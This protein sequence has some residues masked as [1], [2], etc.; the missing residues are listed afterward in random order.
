[1]YKLSDEKRT[2]DNDNLVLLV[3]GN[4]WWTSFKDRIKNLTVVYV[5]W[6]ALN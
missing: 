3:D 1:M 6:R 5:Q 4:K 2:A